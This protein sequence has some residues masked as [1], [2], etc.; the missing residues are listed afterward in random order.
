MKLTANGKNKLLESAN[1]V[2]LAYTAL[3][4]FKTKKLFSTPEGEKTLHDLCK[5][6]L[7]NKNYDQ[8]ILINNVNYRLIL[9]PG[10]NNTYKVQFARPLS[11]PAN[12]PVKKLTT[13]EDKDVLHLLTNQDFTLELPASGGEVSVSNRIN[14]DYVIGG[15]GKVDLYRTHLVTLYNIIQKIDSEED[16]TNLLVALA[17]GSGKTFVQALWLLILSLSNNNAIFG[18][19]DKLA[20]QFVKDLKR[21]LPNALVNKILVLREKTDSPEVE[22]AV[23]S[24][25]HAEGNGT[26]IV[27]SSERLLDKHYQDMMDASSEHTFLAFDEQHLIMKAERRRIRLI[28]LSKKKLSM[29]LTATPNEETYALSGNKPVAIMSN[30]QKEAAGQGQFPWVY[31]HHAQNVSDRNKLKDYRFWTLEFWRNRFHAFLLSIMNAMQEEKSSAAVSLVED[32][33][34]Y[35]HRKENE[36]SVRWRMQVPAARKMLCVIDDN[37]TLVN[38]CYAVQ[39]APARRRDVYSNGNVINRA[40]VATF[41]QIP[42]PEVEVIE[43]ALE[44][45]R[46]EYRGSLKADEQEIGNALANKTLAEQMQDNIFHNLIEYVLTDITGLDEIEHNRLRKHNMDDFKKLVISRFTLRTADYYQQKLAKMI[47]AEGA[48]VIGELLSNLSGVLHSMIGGDYPYNQAENHSDLANF[49]DNWP[50]YDELIKKIKGEDSRFAH[51]FEA[52]AKSHLIMGVMAG[53]EDA[54]TPVE[55]SHPFLG[56]AQDNYPLYDH[57]GTLISKAKK[58]KHTSLEILNDHSR[59]TSFTPNYVHITE[60]IADNYSNLGFIGVYAS[61]KKSEGFSDRN[62]HTVINIAEEKLSATNSPV[63]NL[64][65]FGRNRGLDDNIEP[66]YIHSLGR[67]QEAVFNLDH[68][69]RDDYYPELFKAQKKY[70]IEYVQIVGRQVSQKTITWIYTNLEKDE[71]INPD[72]LKRQVLKFIAQALRE[73]NNKNSHQIKLSRAQ[74]TDVINYAMKGIDK[75]IAHINKPYQVSFYIRTLGFIV[76]FLAECYYFM[77]RI[78]AAI[79]IYI[80]SWMGKRTAPQSEVIPI[81]ADDVYIK[82][83][84]NTNFKSLVANI[85]SVVE[86]RNWLS[87]KLDG[88]TTRVKKNVEGY[89]KKEMSDDFKQHQ[90]KFLEPLLTKMVIDSKKE[91]VAK[92]LAAFPQLLSLFHVNRSALNKL[93]DTNATQFEATLLAVLQQIPGLEDLISTDII[94]YPKNMASIQSLLTEHPENLLKDN[95]ELQRAFSKQLGAYLKGDFLKHL[96]AFIVYPNVKE[97]EQ[98]LGKKNNAQQFV[99]HCLSKLIKNEIEFS[100]KAI[101]SELKSHFKIEEFNRLDE[102]VQK[103]QEEFSVLEAEIKNNLIQS[104]DEQHVRSLNSIVT[105]QLLPV[106]VNIYPLENRSQLL[107]EASDDVKVRQ[108]ISAHGAELASLMKDKQ[109]QLPNFIFSKLISSALPTQIDIEQHK[110]EAKDFVTKKLKE[111]MNTNVLK[112]TL[113]KVIA[114]SSW[115]LRPKYLYDV[116]IANF[117]R[118]DDFLNR[119]SIMLPHDQWIQLKANMRNDRSGVISIA[120]VFIDKAAKGELEQPS[121][122]ELIKLF[123]QQFDTNY[124]GSEEAL[125]RTSESM[126]AFTKQISDNPIAALNQNM[127]NKYTQLVSRRLLPIFASFIKDDRNKKMFLAVKRDDKALYDFITQN[128]DVLSAF[129]KQSGDEVQKKAHSLINQL[130]PYG[131]KLVSEDIIDPKVNATNSA[132]TIQND[133]QKITLITFLSS[134]AFSDLMKDFLGPQDFALLKTYLNSLDHIKVLVD[135]MMVHGI[136]SLDKE[137]IFNIIKS[138][139]PI[140]DKIATM[141]YRAKAFREFISAMPTDTNSISMLDRNKMSEMVSDLINPIIFHKRFIA[142]ID[143]ILGFL[144]EQDLTLLLEALHYPEPAAEAKQMVQ[145]INLIRIQDKEALKRQF[146]SIPADL[147]DFDLEKLPAKKLLSALKDLMEEVLD[148]HCYY[149]GHDRRG[150]NWISASEPKILTKISANLRS[151]QISSEDS[152]FFRY[153]YFAQRIFYINAINAGVDPGGQINAEANKHTINLL[154]RVKS[155]ILNPLWWS[156]NVSHFSH[157]VI[158]TCRDIAQGLI[159]RYYGAINALKSVLNENIRSDYFKISSK[160]ADSEDY[161]NTAF[162]FAEEVN[163][164]SPLDA[165]Q[166]KVKDCPIDVVTKLEDF[167]VHRS[168]RPGFFAGISDKPVVVE[169]DQEL[170]LS[171]RA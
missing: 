9:T 78:P 44:D 165:E 43:K 16:I 97:I 117:L 142:V 156:T 77:L 144:D 111:I 24:L 128:A 13:Y 31:T 150:S 132:T 145:F 56:L 164:L 129:S 40:D 108:L 157:R 121:P 154:Q 161:N 120:R 10:S 29:F 155:H 147:K 25:A 123:N 17:T 107:E 124:E 36:A 113:G 14:K 99:Q 70:D 103:L 22:A 23:T 62:L 64:Q 66:A 167:V 4:F 65:I 153:N 169:E 30:A 134:K 42:D 61:N 131:S 163:D 133:I 3:D 84:S 45:K 148:C 27:G 26:M 100:A 102:E 114:P 51:K 53:M 110:T 33:P 130:L 69:Q 15:I 98:I 5:S 86:L 85:F 166:V 162:D 116:P 57:N 141:D 79:K 8:T 68:L 160:H 60:E 72:R 58:R 81:H 37:E 139:D 83:L 115:N 105:N 93:L 21:L 135:K 75:E 67:K 152:V 151:T 50:L 7:V 126:Q 71:S 74:L 125:K 59:E 109:E 95:H 158:K 20:V 89:I 137:A 35:Y 54:E 28:E 149:N 49:I 63:T 46:S 106:L 80:H 39:H 92:A 127:K 34:F 47:D 118:S 138:S 32:L 52:Y 94:N 18:V 82:I 96:S 76:N 140:L 41:F 11:S 168:T 38:F 6:A 73:L 19:P 1:K 90:Q 171:I 159:A 88:A 146:L 104:L 55:E 2:Y 112:L 143:E 48:Q 101:F 119:I 91:Q 170:D 12:V 122:E 87:R 136:D